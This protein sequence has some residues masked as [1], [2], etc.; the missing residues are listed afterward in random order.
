MGQSD[1]TD[2]L[3]PPFFISV[4]PTSLR[5]PLG[6]FGFMRHSSVHIDTYL[7][8]GC[9]SVSGS[10]KHMNTKYLTRGQNNSNTNPVTGDITYSELKPLHYSE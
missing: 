5:R 1:H 4:S 10:P 9:H 2:K 7:P 6:T 8:G 3:F